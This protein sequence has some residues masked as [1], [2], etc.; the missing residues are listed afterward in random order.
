MCSQRGG[1][2]SWGIDGEKNTWTDL[3]PGQALTFDI[4]VVLRTSLS[5]LAFGLDFLLEKERMGLA[6][7]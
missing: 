1:P 4:Y 6:G 7:L 2:L 5:S 3:D